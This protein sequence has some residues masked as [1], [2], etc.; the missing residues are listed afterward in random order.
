MKLLYIGRA[1]EFADE[2]SSLTNIS[3]GMFSS[4]LRLD[5]ELQVFWTVPRALSEDGKNVLKDRVGFPDRLHPLGLNSSL[6]SRTEGYFFTED[7]W[8]LL[9]QTKTPVAYDLVVNAKPALASVFQTLLTNKY[10][11][12]RY[13]VPVP[14]INW[15]MWTATDLQYQA[16]P[17][18]YAGEYD[19]LAEQL[20]T[21]YGYNVYESDYLQEQSYATMRKYVKPS[22]LLELR[23]RGTVVANGIDVARLEKNL[24]SAERR[25]TLVWGGRLANQK[26]YQQTFEILD[27]V[28]RTGRA[29]RVVVSTQT[30]ASDD[31]AAKVTQDYPAFDFRAG[32]GQGDWFRL[33]SEGDVSVCLARSESYGVTWLEMLYAGVAIV[34]LKAPWQSGVV[35][36]GYPYV[37]E[38]VSEV[39]PMVMSILDDLPQ[40]KSYLKDEVKPWV[41]ERHSR[42]AN[43]AKMLAVC[44]SEVSC[45]ASP[46]GSVADLVLEAARELS[47]PFDILELGERMT[48]LS[49]SDRVWGKSGDIVSPLWLRYVLVKNGY[50]DVGMGESVLFQRAT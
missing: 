11:A 7:L 34:Y 20:S 5:P 19:V 13:H 22:V 49:S 37:V 39:A 10:Q 47:V 1:D 50:R 23:K 30:P 28:Y 38:H 36:S 2:T 14:M 15:Q 46:S 26:R 18:Y 17:E 12:R 43:A 27:Q 21:F 9:S 8:Y 35:P 44:S 25:P 16:V 31:R 6:G 32:V 3:V 41:V 29:A 4:M 40:V 33:L 48:S 45:S 42:D 24:F